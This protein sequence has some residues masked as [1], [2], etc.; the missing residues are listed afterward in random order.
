MSQK[1]DEGKNQLMMLGTVFVLIV[2]LM[3]FMMNFNRNS[4]KANA[5]TKTEIGKNIGK[6]NSIAS[7][8][9]YQVLKVSDGDTINVQKV[10]NGKLVDE[11]VK[12]RMYGIDAPEKTQDYG[13][14]SRAA[15]AKII[16]NNLV[17]IEVKNR[18][19]YGRSVAVVYVNGKNVNQEM[20]RTGN[21][22]W[23]YEYDK[24]DTEMEQLQANAKKNKLGLFSKRGYVEPWIYRKEKKSQTST[25]PRV[26]RK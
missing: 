26:R 13:P 2:I 23:Y 10:E 3:A 15:L 1:V 11:V 22:W 24:K 7:N 17:E 14:E 8:G 5:G 18:D 6:N 4:N 21:A 20:V 9:K 19:R 16:G 25:K 12:I